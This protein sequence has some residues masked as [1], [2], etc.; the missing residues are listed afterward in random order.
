MI[1]MK[2]TYKLHIILIISLSLAGCAETVKAENAV[3]ALVIQTAEGKEI[4]YEVEI[5]NT[6]ESRRRGLMF[7]T[8][9][10][11]NHGMLLD[12]GSPAKVSIWMKN[13]Y[14]SLDIIYIDAEGVINKIVHH[15]VPHSTTLM[16]S[17]K[18]VRAVLELNA[19]QAEY[20]GIKPGDHVVHDAF[21]TRN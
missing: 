9:M 7:R 3:D 21:S 16:N 8:E 15:A 11:S 20:H 18:K 12:F 19:G 4:N 2:H 10:P 5:A 17:D 1:H 14:L 13:T 6:I